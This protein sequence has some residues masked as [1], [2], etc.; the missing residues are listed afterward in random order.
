ASSR[1]WDL[2]GAL[3]HQ[4]RPRQTR[5]ETP[6]GLRL[7]APRG[8]R[9]RLGAS[10]RWWMSSLHGR[11]LSHADRFVDEA[12][13]HAQDPDRERPVDKSERVA[14]GVHSVV[15]AVGAL[16]SED[17]R[18]ASFDERDVIAVE[19]MEGRIRT[20]AASAV[21]RTT[22]SSTSPPI[23]ELPGGRR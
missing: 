14:S 17:A 20:P 13:V 4:R 23:G 5:V 8:A 19:G 9:R 10:L 22:M 1:R 12:D 2:A 7:P 15:R 21:A 16:D 3:A 11:L 6:K 18:D